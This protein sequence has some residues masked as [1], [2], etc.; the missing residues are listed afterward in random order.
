M[1]LAACSDCTCRQSRHL[2]GPTQDVLQ[3]RSSALQNSVQLE[4][5]KL[6]SSLSCKRLS[7]VF[8]GAKVGVVRCRVHAQRGG[9]LVGD[10][11]ARASHANWNKMSQLFVRGYELDP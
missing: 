4:V 3:N 6:S 1:A 8:Q 10:S 9:G 11:L 5:A 2:R 7:S